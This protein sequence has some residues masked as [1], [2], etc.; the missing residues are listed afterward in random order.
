MLLSIGVTGCTSSP[1]WSSMSWWHKKSDAAVAGGEAPKYNPTASTNPA[2]PSANQNPNNSL[3][4][5]PH[6]GAAMAAVAAGNAA[7]A[8]GAAPQNTAYPTTPYQQAKLTPATS[9]GSP[10]NGTTQNPSV[11]TGYG[12][13][14]AMPDRYAAGSAA[15]AT[16]TMAAASPYG[17]AAATPGAAGP[18]STQPQTGFYNPTYDG[19]VAATRYASG[20]A[21][22]NAANSSMT[23]AAQPQYN[24]T[25]NNAMPSNSMPDISAPAYRTADT[26]NSMASEAP[27]AASVNPSAAGTNNPTVGDRYSGYVSNGA[28]MA[29]A[30]PASSY[31]PA[32]TVAPSAASGVGDRYAQPAAGYD[33]AA[34]SFQPATTNPV[35]NTGYNPID[36]SSGLPAR[37][38]TEYRPGGTSNY[39]SPSGSPV[40]PGSSGVQGGSPAP[41]GATPAGYQSAATGQSTPGVVNA[42]A[43]STPGS[44]SEFYGA[45]QGGTSQGA[46]QA[47]YNTPASEPAYGAPNPV[48]ATP[49]LLPTQKAGW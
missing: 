5:M 3:A 44:S 18:T 43:T 45:Y 29:S 9:G 8:P 10:W 24:P 22:P 16:N 17:A 36:S 32:T 25:T 20:A 33:P 38:S 41:S 7:A 13:A 46:A 1:T 6:S 28:S 27:Q 2:L 31:A 34:N 48:A 30:A 42:L 49:A 39:T 21:I 12:V 40:Q 15:G 4:G 14:G 35:G 23:A 37:S 11:P 26:R 19:G 47:I